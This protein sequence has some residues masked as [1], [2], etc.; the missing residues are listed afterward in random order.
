M[1]FTYSFDGTRWSDIHAA[2]VCSFLTGTAM[3]T[4]DFTLVLRLQS[5]GYGGV[6]I[7]ALITCAILPLVLLSPVT[8]RMADRFDSRA[9]MAGAGVT[10]CAA[11][12]A[13]SFA[14]G[15]PVLLAL[16]FVNAS[17]NAA[18]R[19]ALSALV[20]TM[21]TEEDLPRAVATVQT[22]MLLG[23]TAGPAGAGF[24][25]AAGG[26]GAALTSA[27]LCAL[28]AALLSCDIR[29]RRGGIRRGAHTARLENGGRSW[30][31]RRDVIL[32][33]MVIGAAAVIGALCAVNVL[34][35]F[36]VREVYGA[37]EGVYGLINA[38]WTGGMVVGAWVA[39]EIFRRVNDGGQ[40]A[41]LLMGCLACTGI[42]VIALGLPLPTVA[43]LIPLYLFGGILNAAENSCMQIAVARRVPERFRGRATA[44][45]NAVVN[46]STLIG[47]AAGGVLETVLEVRTSFVLVG[48]IS[49]AIVIACL[50]LVRR[51]VR[52]EE[53]DVKDGEEPVLVAA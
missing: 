6:A 7:A 53:A 29:T 39:A 12:A 51:G 2:A 11:I 5:T 43:L 30:L 50:P 15:L 14:D 8:G 9:V 38:C 22:G 48:L 20:P 36:L 47:F 28:T 16:V 1:S 40:I 31:L 21:A 42:V 3:F 17:A 41:M 10:Q 34:E 4:A 13:M 32:L 27:A 44:R 49:V 46:A 19:P 35:V 24:I 45:V 52:A 25:I 26:T 33:V 18:L 37:S 23:M